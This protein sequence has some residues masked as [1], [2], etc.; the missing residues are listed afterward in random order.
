MTELSLH[1]RRIETIFQLLGEKENDI[2]YSVGWALYRCPSF[3]REFLHK[4]VAYDSD[5]RDVAIRLQDFRKNQGIT[6]IEIELPSKF[7]VIAE[8]KHGWTL[9][10]LSQLARYVPRLKKRK[11]PVRKIIVLTGCSEDFANCNLPSRKLDGIPVQPISWRSLIRMARSAIPRGKHVE[12]RLLRDLLAYF[13]RIMTMQD[14]DSNW[15]YVVAIGRGTKKG[16]GISWIDMVEKKR[17]YFHRMGVHGWPKE[18]PNYIAFRYR[19]RLQS[20]HHI[21]QHRVVNDLHDAFKEI[22]SKKREPFL[23]YELGPPIKPQS[24][25]RTGNIYAN[26]R[27]WCMLDTLF[28]S[29]TIAEARDLSHKREKLAKEQD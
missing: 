14:I 2:T 29:S 20:I 8:A 3:L 11:S 4:T 13:A 16:W 18:P 19:G 24:K 5:I 6:D 27:V 21:E 10:S 23:V 26:G 7:H 25:V 17:R 9:P 22:P 15:V 28:T 1:N 12:K